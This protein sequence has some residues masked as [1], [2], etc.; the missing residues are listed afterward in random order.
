MAKRLCLDPT[1]G[2]S[3]DSSSDSAGASSS[4]DSASASSSASSFDSASASSSAS[5]SSD[6]T[7]V[8]PVARLLKGGVTNWGTKA[9]ARGRVHARKLK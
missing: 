7:L 8:R 5:S 6:Y 9:M 3:S 4:F 1:A 2:A